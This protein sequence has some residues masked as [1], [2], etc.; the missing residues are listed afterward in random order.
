MNPHEHELTYPWADVPAPGTLTTLR[1]G[2]HW[3]R[4]PLPFA[5]DHINLWLL[6]DEI[7]G[8]PGFTAVDC[9]I[10]SDETRAA[11]ERIFDTRFDGKPLL[12]VL[13]THFHPDHFGLAWWL[14]DGGD[15]KCWQAPLWMTLG[16]YAFGR[17]LST[18]KGEY[19]VEAG[20][21]AA[22]HFA[23]HGLRDPASLEKIVA[24]GSNHYPRLVPATPP[25]F[26]R[27]VDGEEIAIGPHGAKRLFRVLIGF[28]HAPEHVSLHNASDGLL[29]S[30][31]MVLPRI[32]TNVSVFEIEPEG[33]PLPRYLR[34]LDHYL[35]LPADT[36]VLP[37]HGK[38]FIGLHRRVVQQHE[39]HQARLDEVLAACARPVDGTEIVRV[40]FKRE[41]DLHQMTFALG[42]A[43]AHLHAL[44]YDGK[45]E[46]KHG[47]DGV[48][49]FVQA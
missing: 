15:R 12:R 19:A 22:A 24:R 31:D 32:S 20:K 10:S 9:G 29:I 27:I 14:T 8:R 41:L 35:M 2:V 45:V 5:L 44:W 48:F 30:G 36:L 16:E 46:R 25:S 40:M 26:R 7:D 3:L 28:G 1:P 37:S 17:M 13:T 33:N 39:H 21:R 38:P 11:W 6:D 49:R 18:H 42:E 23:A 34:S 43:L 4:M 47:G